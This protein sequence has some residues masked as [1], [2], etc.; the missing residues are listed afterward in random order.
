MGIDKKNNCWL[1]IWRQNHNSINLK[2]QKYTNAQFPTPF[3]TRNPRSIIRH[4]CTVF[5]HYHW[6][7]FVQS[8]DKFVETLL[9]GQVESIK[10]NYKHF[11][12]FGIPF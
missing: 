6:I 9:S 4:Q 12:K 1:V 8:L 7:V 10:I 5:S 2:S 11:Q 3:A